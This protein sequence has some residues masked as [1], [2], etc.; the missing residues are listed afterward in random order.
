MTLLAAFYV[1]LYRYS[2][3]E[4]LVVGSPIANRNRP[5]VEGLIG[6]F[7]NTF[8]LRVRLLREPNLQRISVAGSGC[9][10]GSLCPSRFAF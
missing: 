6:F 9:L 7:V 10:L 8:V 5:E 3:Q 4:D 1:L 2:G